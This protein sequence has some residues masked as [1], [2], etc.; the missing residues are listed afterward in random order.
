MRIAVICTVKCHQQQYPCLTGSCLN[1]VSTGQGMPQ[2]QA[3]ARFGGQRMADSQAKLIDVARLRIGLF[4]YLDLSWTE[5]PFPF[6]SFKLRS[7]DQISTIRNLGLQRIRYSPERSD[8]EPLPEVAVVA[9]A[10]PEVESAEPQGKR[11][12]EAAKVARREQL[13]AQQASLERCER[14]FSQA[15]RALRS[16]MQSARSKPESAR[17]ELENLIGSMVAEMTD[18]REVAIRLLSEKAGEETAL[19]PLNVTVLS[20][21]L[22]RACGLDEDTLLTI[23]QGA[24]M[25]D[26]GK[27]DL[28]DRLHYADDPNTSAERKIF[29]QHVEHGQGI[30]QR[31]GLRPAVIRV[32]NEHHENCDGT[33]YPI[34]LRGDQLSAA[35]KVVCLVNHYDNL[36]SPGNPALAA[37]PP[38]WPCS[39][40]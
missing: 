8:V 6:N 5:H 3:V 13:R 11:A 17:E 23:G 20:V 9:V 7:Q 2:Q 29:Q 10:D 19:H 21:L 40:A 32:I 35:S 28:P 30:A 31:M 26:V 33:G 15:S 1:A 4:V 24:L 12:E 39:F 25:H 38:P 14:A 22:G 34:G 27:L 18:E 16:V 36:V 37:T